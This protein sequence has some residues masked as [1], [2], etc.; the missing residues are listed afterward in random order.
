MNTTR[1]SR[2]R[3]STLAIHRNNIIINS[4]ATQLVKGYVTIQIMCTVHLPKGEKPETDQVLTQ[5]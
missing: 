4:D 5:L 2:S 1:L 3:N